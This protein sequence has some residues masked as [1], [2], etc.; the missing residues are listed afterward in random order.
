MRFLVSEEVQSSLE[1]RN[2]PINKR[3][4]A[5]MAALLLDEIRAGGYEAY[6]FDLENN[7]RLF[8]ELVEQINVV[9]TS[10]T[11]IIGFVRHELGRFFNGEVS[12]EEAARN[13]QSRL[14][15]YLRE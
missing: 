2:N 15:M 10:D 1:L 14:N 5:E 13:L 7:I 9:E 8:N 12:A 6:G 4:S 3:A 11:F